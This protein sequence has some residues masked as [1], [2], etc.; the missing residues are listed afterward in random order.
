MKRVF[1][2]TLLT[3]ALGASVLLSGGC[4]ASTGRRFETT[5]EHKAHVFRNRIYHPDDY[6]YTNR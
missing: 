3:F 6:R 2:V 1:V 4:S 5:R